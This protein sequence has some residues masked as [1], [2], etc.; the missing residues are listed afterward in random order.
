M[1]M[2]EKK[3]KDTRKAEIEKIMKQ[4]NKEKPLVKWG[5]DAIKEQEDN[6][7]YIRTGITE[8]DDLLGGGIPTG[9]IVV[10]NGPKGSGKTGTCTQMMAEVT[11]NKQYVL[12]LCTEPPL[13]TKMWK[14]LGVDGDYVIVQTPDDY[15]EQMVDSIDEF[16]FD[17]ETRKPKNLI[18]L[19]ILDSENNI[20]PK[21]I[22]DKL[23]KEGA[24]GSAKMAARATLTTQF[25]TRIQ[26]RGY[27][28]NGALCVV[29]AQVRAN[30]NA[31]SGHGPETKMAGAEALKHDP[32]I[33]INFS[34]YPKVDPKTKIV[35]GIEITWKISS[36]EKNNFNSQY[37][38]GTYTVIP[39]VGIDDGEML[40]NRGVDWGYVVKDKSLG[41]SGLRI[42][43]P[44]GDRIAKDIGT[45]R[46]FFKYD[47]ELRI[48]MRNLYKNGKP[49]EAPVS[50]GFVKQVE[51][52]EGVEEDNIDE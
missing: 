18:K 1:L 24:E 42:L 31:G 13:N 19:I 34:G 17:K 11:Q 15:G 2:E 9:M 8:L 4:R 50:V 22:I 51:L 25:L 35:R 39:G 14:A 43:S 32:K 38:K 21:S 16:F 47:E 12:Y 29:V 33:I 45:A 20:V 23:D 7:D 48:L 36:S 37:G 27:L 28:R 3:E 41:R 6:Q 40:F 44:D 30:M 5:V 52:P 49:K 46:E 10:F 26:G